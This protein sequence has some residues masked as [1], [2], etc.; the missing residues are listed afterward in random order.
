MHLVD[1][2]HLVFTNLRW[3]AGLF[4]ECLDMLYRV[5]GGGI[6]FEDVER[7][8]LVEGL[9]TFTVSACLPVF[10]G[11]ETVDSLGKDTCAGSLSYTSRTAKQ[12]GVSQFAALHSILQRSGQCLLSHYGIECGR[13]V[14]S[15][16]YD[17]FFHVINRF[18]TQ[19]Y[20]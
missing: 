8:L 9:A 1:D 11:R 16:R 15:C 12:V 2:K 5:V 7:P 18:R 10:S 19:R 14:F 20:D 13:A 17:I 3:Y 4:H 6:E